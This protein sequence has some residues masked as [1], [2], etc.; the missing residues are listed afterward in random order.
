MR[1]GSLRDGSR[2]GRLVVVSPDMTRAVEAPGA[3]TLQAALDEWD[4]VEQGLAS[5]ARDLASRRVASFPLDPSA[6]VAPLPR[7]LAFIDSS[8]YLSHMERARALRGATLP[9]TYR[10]EPLISL[11]IGSP[12]M[13]AH[14]QIAYAEEL[15]LDLEAE[16]AVITGDVPAGATRAQAAA[17]VRLVTL[18]NDVSLRAVIAAETGAGRS[19]YRGKAAPAM[20]PLAVTPDE[21]GP[22]W[23]GMALARP[24]DISINGQR[25]GSPDAGRD[26]AFDFADIIAYAATWRPLSAGTLVASGTV[27]NVDP[28]AG[29]ACIAEARM[30]ETTR[31]GAPRTPWLKPGDRVTIDSRDAAGRS[32]FGAID[33]RVA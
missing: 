14:A 1:L 30:I 31:H 17:A 21:L 33:Q 6:L 13:P 23:T 22:A 29:T 25:L 9:D 4:A 19:V 27:S 20:A 16:V 18:V 26:A 5:T 12:M 2:D 28:A 24:L 10:R 32:L 15:D 11:R 8:V 3:A 7:P